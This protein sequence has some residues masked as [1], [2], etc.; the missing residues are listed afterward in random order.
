MELLALK[1]AAEIVI[2]YVLTPIA[3]GA[4]AKVGEISLEKFPAECRNLWQQMNAKLPQLA[5]ALKQ[6]NVKPL[7]YDKAVLELEAAAQE[8]LELREAVQEVATQAQADPQLADEIAKIRET[9]KS[10]QPT[11][12]NSAKLAEKIA[13]LNQGPIN[14]QTNHFNT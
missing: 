6:A 13:F 7:D 8:D 5:A 10:Q 3:Q 1:A 4:L 9:L 11:I 12:H 2:S 14:S